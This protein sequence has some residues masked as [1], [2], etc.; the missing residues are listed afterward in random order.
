MLSFEEFFQKKKI[1]LQQMQRAEPALFAEFS[2]HYLLMGEKSFDHTKK[3]WFNQLRRTFPFQQ[4]AKPHAVK[5]EAISE[6]AIQ[7]VVAAAAQ[8]LD[9]TLEKPKFKEDH[10]AELVEENVSVKEVSLAE[11]E[12]LITD[13]EAKTPTPKPVFKPRFDT[14][15]IKKP[16]NDLGKSDEEE[17]SKEHERVKNTSE[18]IT[19]A[20][21]IKPETENSEPETEKAKPAF[22]PRF[23]VQNNKKE[24]VKEA[25]ELEIEKPE[26]ETSQPE[27]P[28]YKPR[29]QMKNMNKL[30]PNDSI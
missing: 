25:P 9:R 12:K 20:E 14:K 27:K 6:M 19:S 17:K 3:Y 1:D 13:A 29:F 18:E 10:L 5:A 30:P 16:E 24:P 23:N 28:A 7:G 21:K 15:N 11:E 26:A 22:K 2:K 8:N 4:E